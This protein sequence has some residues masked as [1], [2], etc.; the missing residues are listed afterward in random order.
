[1]S[2]VRGTM[3]FLREENSRLQQENE[4]LRNELVRLRMVLRALRTLHEVTLNISPATDVVALLDRI[5]KASL[6][7]IGAMDGSLMLV[8]EEK[9]E[10]AFAVVHGSV[11]DTLRGYRIPLG[12]GIAGWVA[13]HGE[14]V[15]LSDARLDSRFSPQVDNV[16]HFHTRSLLCVPLQYNGRTQGVIQ[17]LNKSNGREFTQADLMLLGAVAQIASAAIHKAESVIN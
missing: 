13:K 9:N 6:V 8:D 7:S 1:M 4:E 16:F 10:M 14:P 5:L 15:M 2:E 12:T 11:R 17:A 3:H